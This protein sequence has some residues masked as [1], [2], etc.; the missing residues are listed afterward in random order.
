MLTTSDNMWYS[1]DNKENSVEGR[2]RY[3]DND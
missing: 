2:R 3:H 1:L